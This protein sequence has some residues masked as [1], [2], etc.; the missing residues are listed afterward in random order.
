[1]A[2]ARARATRARPLDRGTVAIVL[3]AGASSRM[4]RPKPL[5][6]LGGRTM[7]DRVLS[8][9]REARIGRIVVVLGDRADQV[10]RT[11]DLRGV[12]VVTNPE[13][14]DGMSSSLRAGV[15][16]TSSNDRRAFIVLGDQPLLA[17][18][19]LRSLVR[20]AGSGGGSIFVPTYRG[21]WGNPVLFDLSLAPELGTI[22]GDVGC[23][24]MFPQH[25]SEI[26]EVEVDDPG[27][28]VDFD[29]E[30][31]L[32]PVVAALDAGRS[33]RPVLE[34][35]ASPRVALHASP[36]EHLLPRR[37][38]FIEPSLPKPTLLVVGDSPVATSL[39]TMA[40]VL[41]YRVVMVAPGTDARDLPEVD[42]LVTDLGA[43]APHLGPSTYAVVASMGKYDDSALGPI[44][45]S[46]VAFVGLVAS[47][48]RATSVI[49]AIRED[50]ITAA[51]AA[52]IRCPA[53]IDIAAATPE[54]IALSILAE[55]TRVRRTAPASASSGPAPAGGTPVASAPVSIAVDPVCHM[56]VETGTARQRTYGGTTYYFCGDGCRRQF[57]AAP[58]KFLPA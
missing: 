27:I 12:T 19:T 35:L 23:R 16:A 56:Q 44:A 37:R 4:G 33:V 42:A 55:I 10:R 15:H 3:A 17:P 21:V 18:A 9:V 11:V 7:L 20:R 29:T 32:R 26:R 36:D 24:G 30:D 47:R 34:A 28:L 13:F 6:E 39:A 43:L 8:V 50:G 40:P 53:G 45:R 49:A 2:A 5:V 54:E 57:R 52:R 51:E 25:T 31:E 22:R 46:P 1:M 41:G 48:K 58:A 14:R 38:R